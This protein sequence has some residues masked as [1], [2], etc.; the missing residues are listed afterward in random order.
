MVGDDPGVFKVITLRVAVTEADL[1]TY[2]GTS[3]VSP[4]VA[5]QYQRWWPEGE[6]RT[7]QV[8]GLPVADVVARVT[9]TLDQLFD[10]DAL[11]A[12]YEREREAHRQARD[13]ITD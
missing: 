2:A 9:N 12:A 4:A 1:D 13:A 6:T 7:L 8:E 3:T 5:E 11:D 10:Q